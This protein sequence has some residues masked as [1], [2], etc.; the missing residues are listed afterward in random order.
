MPFPRNLLE[1][2]LKEVNREK[3]IKTKQK[4]KRNLKNKRPKPKKNQNNTKEKKIKVNT[5]TRKNPVLSRKL[6][7]TA[8]ER[9]RKMAEGNPGTAM[10]Q[11]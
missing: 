7:V 8:Q 6:K 4:T 3:G 5:H 2:V 11:I 10:Y 1:A 9:E